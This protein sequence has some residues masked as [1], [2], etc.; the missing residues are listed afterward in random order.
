[1][2]ALGVGDGF[3]AV[4]DA[5]FLEDCGELLL[6]EDA[7]ARH[8]LLRSSDEVLQVRQGRRD[9]AQVRSGQRIDSVP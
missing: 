3:G 1:M 2:L 7:G 6:G 8:P 9:A 4:G 5:G